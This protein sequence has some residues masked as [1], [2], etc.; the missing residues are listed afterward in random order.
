MQNVNTVI[1]EGFLTDDPTFRD[2]R[3]GVQFA[4]LRLATNHDYR[5]EDGNVV[6]RAFYHNVVVKV[7]ST[8]QAIRSRLGKGSRVV[9]QGRL[10]PRAYQKDGETRYVHEVVVNPYSGHIGFLDQRAVPQ[11]DDDAPSDQG[12][13]DEVGSLADA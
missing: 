6:K 3:D 13:E 1:L 9:V 7:P 11:S 2:I 10:E 12:T 5:A 4:A 8:V